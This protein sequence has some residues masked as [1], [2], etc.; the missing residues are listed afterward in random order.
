MDWWNKWFTKAD[1]ISI[2]SKDSAGLDAY[3]GNSREDFNNG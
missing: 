1:V 3:R 2:A